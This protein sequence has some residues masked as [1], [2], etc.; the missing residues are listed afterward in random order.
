MINAIANISLN[1]IERASTDEFERDILTKA[2]AITL[3]PI[4]FLEL[5]VAATLAW[6]LPGRLS[7][8]AL[9]A[10]VPS[11]AGTSLSLA[12]MRRRIATPTVRSNWTLTAL[13]L[14]PMF[15]CFAGIAYHAFALS[16]AAAAPY[17]IGATVGAITAVLLSPTLRRKQNRRD[18][19]RLDAELED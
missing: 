13:Y 4:T 6:S 19:S 1:H 3:T 11:I 14:I 16:D 17:L 5:I 9:L 15:L 18:Q 10:I 2:S 7:L 8:L 12:W